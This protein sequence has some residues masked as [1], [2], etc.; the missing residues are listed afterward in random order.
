[1]VE[2]INHIYQNPVEAGLVFRAEDYRYI[3]AIDYSD[4]KGLL[5]NVVVFRM[6]DI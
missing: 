2:F 3:S 1:M 5:D 4:E 6:F